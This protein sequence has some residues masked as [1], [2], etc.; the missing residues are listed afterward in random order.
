MVAIKSLSSALVALSIVLL[1]VAAQKVTPTSTPTSTLTPTPAPKP[2]PAPTPNWSPEDMARVVD[3]QAQC[4]SLKPPFGHK[5]DHTV[6]KFM[7][8]NP[9]GRMPYMVKNMQPIVQP[10]LKELRKL[11]GKASKVTRAK[12][13]AYVLCNSKTLGKNEDVY[14]SKRFNYRKDRFT[15]KQWT[16]FRTR[17]LPGFRRALHKCR[18]GCRKIHFAK[19]NKPKK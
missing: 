8:M 2:K 16:E 19:Y 15:N 11:K 4:I 10:C 7:R 9:H 14:F 6:D 18:G 3:C 5:P 17:T 13:E 1:G 12:F